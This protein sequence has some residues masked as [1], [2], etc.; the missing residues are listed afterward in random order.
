VK[1]YPPNG[2]AP[3]GND[4]K[5]DEALRKFY[6]FCVAKD[7][8]VFTHCTPVG[9]EAGEDFGC[10]SDPKIWRKVLDYERGRWSMLRLCFGHAGGE[11]GWFSLKPAKPRMCEPPENSFADEAI[12]ICSTKKYPNVYCEFGYLSEV[13]NKAGVLKLQ[14]KL[15]AAIDASEEGREL[16]SRICF[17]TD[18][19][20][21]EMVIKGTRVYVDRL[22]EV[23]KHDKL[24]SH[25]PVFFA[26]NARR[27]LQMKP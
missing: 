26:G 4:R 2:Y 15:I 6:D 17:G 8:P 5:I 19:H 14:T 13:R 27:F 22:R 20:M 18:W 16:A 11:V 7:V 1:F 24:K 21:P 23:F 3:I 12:R 25:A 10:K 9:V